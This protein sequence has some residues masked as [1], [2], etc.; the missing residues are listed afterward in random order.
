MRV[1]KLS[2]GSK[3]KPEM[4]SRGG[5]TGLPRRYMRGTAKR[6]EAEVGE[7]RMS[8]GRCGM[9]LCAVRD[10]VRQDLGSLEGTADAVA[11]F[12]RSRPSRAFVRQRLCHGV[13]LV[14]QRVVDEGDKRMRVQVREAR[15]LHCKEALVGAW[16]RI[17][18][19]GEEMRR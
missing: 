2:G 17:G 9:I 6:A 10:G 15:C 1:R 14:K 8:D 4:V 12:V 19:W 3:S 5:G 7:R 11:V 18:L 16:V 13:K